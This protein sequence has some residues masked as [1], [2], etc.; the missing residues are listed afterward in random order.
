MLCRKPPMFG[1]CRDC[2]LSC[3]AVDPEGVEGSS[4]GWSV[5]RSGTRN[6]WKW[7][8][9]VVLAPEGRWTAH[10]RA[11]LTTRY[12]GSMMWISRRV[13]CS[14]DWRVAVGPSSAPPGREGRVVTVPRVPFAFGEFHPWLQPSAPSGPKADPGR[15]GAADPGA[16]GLRCAL[17][18]CVAAPSGW[19][20]LDCGMFATCCFEVIILSSSQVHQNLRG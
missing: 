2:A 15:R 8:S 1:A 3:S 19:W 9:S 5:P 17:G 11:V 6:P 12:C 18:C 16:P 4:H 13:T 20:R 14:F 7:V 10:A